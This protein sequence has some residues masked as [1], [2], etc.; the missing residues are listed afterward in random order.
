[1]KY[2]RK[3]NEELKPSTYRSAAKKLKAI[4][5]INRSNKLDDWSEESSMRNNIRDM[6]SRIK[7]FSKYGTYTF[8]MGDNKV[9]VDFHI[10][11]VLFDEYGGDDFDKLKEGDYFNIYFELGLIPIDMDNMNKL[12]KVI[13]GISF[14]GGC[15]WDQ[16]VC[17]KFN[18]DG[19]NIIFNGMSIEL[20]G[21]ENKVSVTDRKS[22]V[23][24]RNLISSLFSSDSDY[25]NDNTN[26]P[27]RNLY[28]KLT[29]NFMIDSGYAF[30]HGF[31]FDD[32]VVEIKKSSV[33]KLYLD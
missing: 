17:L 12:I 10:N 5:H 18:Y 32:V 28:E 31:D 15:Y 33:N 7:E 19:E 2:L 8:S 4:G 21:E 13:P 26:E 27:F 25:P 3:F 20:G 1:M 30:D 16:N 9:P 29:K 14:Y 6:N 22:A 24:F 11:L 23:R